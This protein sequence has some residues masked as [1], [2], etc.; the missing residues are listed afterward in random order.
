MDSAVEKAVE[1][2]WRRYG[3]A[4]SLEELADSAGLSRFY[5]ARL[6][7]DT[8]GITP[9]RY[10]AA[11]RVA[12]AKRML[13][14]SSIRV[15]DVAFAVGYNS[16]GSFTNYFSA[17]VGV[18]PGR[19]RRMANAKAFGPPS[20]TAPSTPA[21]TIAGTISLPAGLGN[22]RAL[23]GA[24]PSPLLQH[25]VGA[26]VLVDVP[27]GRPCCYELAQV[28]VGTW[29]VLAVAT[30]ATFAGDQQQDGCEVLRSGLIRVRVSAEGVTSTAVR[31][32]RRHLLDSPVLLALPDLVPR[33]SRLSGDGCP[34]ATP[35][36]ALRDVV[37][38]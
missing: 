24:F 5:F 11:V 35:A 27:H 1:C 12:E 32:R 21:G 8:V 34:V 9:G 19:F 23:V 33:P 4:L 36:E 17:S 20:V 25:P 15:T 10:L 29:Y 38:G 14:E 22:A 16:L 31:M 26:A 18:S 3:E 6:F 7:R 13:L 28:P 2:M 30:A 37:D